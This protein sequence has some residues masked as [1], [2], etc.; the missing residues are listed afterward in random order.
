MESIHITR[1][2]GQKTLRQ[3]HYNH[4]NFIVETTYICDISKGF[5]L[6]VGRN[7]SCGTGMAFGTGWNVLSVH[8]LFLKWS[9]RKWRITTMLKH[10][11]NSF[12]T[13]N[14]QF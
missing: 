4:C 11:D 6:G 1:Q 9:K 7:K 3:T 2:N 10:S 5:S 13:K 12:N 14:K 8:H